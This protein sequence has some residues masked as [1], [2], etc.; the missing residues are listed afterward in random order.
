MQ[1]TET[2]SEGLKRQLKVV[3]G[4]KELSE[5]LEKRVD[6]LKGR[7]NIKGFRPGKVPASYIKKMYGR[8]LMA[9]VLQEA[10]T[11]TSRKA[12]EDRAERPAFNP[13]IKLGEENQ[14]QIE[15]IIAGDADLAYDMNF[16]VI[17]KIDLAD[18]S[19]L[20]IER[21][22][23]EPADED[24]A[25]NLKRILDANREFVAADD[26][27]AQTGDRVIIDFLG[28]IDGVAFEGGAAKDAAVII[29]QG[30]FIPGFEE[31]LIGAKFGDSRMVEAK[32]PDEYSVDTLKGKTATFDVTIKEVAA[33]DTT[34]SED[35]IAKKTGMEGADQLKGFLKDRLQQELSRMSRARAKRSVLDRLDAAHGF[36]L[37]PTLVEN[38]FNEIWGQLTRNLEAA[39]K[40]FADE[41]KTEEGEQAEYRK[42]AERRVRLGLVLSEI[43]EKNAVTVTDDELAQA[44]SQQVRQYPGQEKEIYRIYRENPAL[45]VNLRAPIFEEK[46]VD[47]ILTKV[48]IADQMMSPK[49]L[50]ALDNEDDGRDDMLTAAGAAA[51]LDE[52]HAHPHGHPD[53]V[54]GPDCNHT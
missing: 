48:Q 43:G 42:L 45:L 29:G 32:F 33:P 53:H 47:F 15:K 20:A 24:I 44:L 28:M 27:V 50:M 12:L 35:D 14:E 13:D 10:V 39:K 49:E 25:D 5:R 54:H 23:A 1:V 38:E 26:R 16:E 40:T 6:E 41:G 11:E 18:L 4:A 21:P 52:G 9:E 36:E 22:V 37:P 30:G 2:L 8:S 31:G 17:P 51:D 7:A 3:V 46:V 34:S 19:G